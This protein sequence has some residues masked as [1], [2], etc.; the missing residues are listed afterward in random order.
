MNNTGYTAQAV[1]GS[2][3]V[4]TL[5]RV[6]NKVAAAVPDGHAPMPNTSAQ[7]DLVR[8]GEGSVVLNPEDFSVFLGLRQA[9]I[10]VGTSAVPLPN[11][12]LNSRRALVIHNNGSEAIY[13]GDENV[14]TGNGLPLAASEKIAFDIQGNVKA[15]VYAI[16]GGNVDVRILELA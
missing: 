16:A 12:P 8:I 10:T 15:R 4:P 6:D 9:A 14:T 5:Q 3:T 7:G 13:L 11:N 2:G 1:V